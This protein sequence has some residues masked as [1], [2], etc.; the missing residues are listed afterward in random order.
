MD[1]IPDIYDLFRRNVGYPNF[2]YKYCHVTYDFY[3]IVNAAK[4]FKYHRF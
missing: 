4:N 1:T 2:I 3:L